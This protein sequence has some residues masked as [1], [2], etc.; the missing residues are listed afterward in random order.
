MDQ[1]Q[2]HP[3][4][5]RPGTPP[6]EGQAAPGVAGAVAEAGTGSAIAAA[7]SPAH[8]PTVRGTA[9]VRRGRPKWAGVIGGVSLGLGV[10]GALMGAFSMT[11]PLFTRYSASLMP[12]NAQAGMLAIA[13]IAWAYVALGVALLGLGVMLSIGGAGMLQGK[14]SCRWILLVWSVFKILMAVVE[15]ALGVYVAMEQSAAMA[16]TAPTMPVMAQQAQFYTALAGQSINL[17]F[18]SAWP[19]F[20]LV[21]LNRGVVR[22]EIALWR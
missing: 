17:L 14:R 19:V 1:P 13:D 6:G 16:Q 11:T 8:P 18:K 21:W 22:K 10:M 9:R 15:V 3:E 12:A 4:P 20:L 7:A 2:T 5:L